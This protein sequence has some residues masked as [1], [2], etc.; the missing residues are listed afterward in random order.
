MN[1]F[2]CTGHMHA[3]YLLKE[4]YAAL[5]LPCLGS[6]VTEALH[7]SHLAVNAFFLPSGGSLQ[8]AL[9]FLAGLHIAVIITVVEDNF[10]RLNRNNFICRVIYK[11]AVMGGK[12]HRAAVLLKVAF[13]PALCFEVKIVG[14]LIQKE[15]VRVDKKQLTKM[16]ARLPAAAELQRAAVKILFAKTQSGKDN[17]CPVG[18]IVTAAGII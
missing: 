8:D 4:L 2:T 17:L 16:D 14:G 12:K 10:R 15:Y 6:L 1:L 5:H 11:Y 7:K 3:L 18:G 9:F 13:K